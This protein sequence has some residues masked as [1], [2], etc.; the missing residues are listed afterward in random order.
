MSEIDNLR[1][2]G[3]NDDEVG[4]WAAEKRTTLQAAGFKDN[5]IDAYL[6]GGVTV[7]DN[8]PDAMVRRLD[9]GEEAR[10][11]E[12]GLM[13]TI[14]QFAHMV[15]T[16][17][18]R[19]RLW[20]AVKSYPEQ[21]MKGFVDQLKVPGDVVNGTIDLNT[22]EGLDQAIGLGTLVGLG[23][24]NKL[25]A[26]GKTS[27][28]SVNMG[29]PVAR[30]ERGPIGE[31]IDV[32]VG[33]LPRATDF[34][35]TARTIG[36]DARM[37]VQEKLLDL[38]ENKGIHPAEIAADAARDPVVKQ[39]IL[40]SD[41]ADLPNYKGG[42]VPPPEKPPAAPP[43]P[44]EPPEPGSFEAAQKTVLDKVS[45]GERDAR[46]MS[47]D[48]L[49]TEAIDDLH[50]I[51]A[52][53]E[54]AYQLARLTRGQFGKAAHFLEQGTFDF[55]T[56]K[57][58]GKPLKE[59]LAPVR[60]DLDG[61]RAYLTAKR[62][63]EIEGQGKKS[64]IETAAARQVVSEGAAKF[65]KA[66]AGIVEFQQ[67]QLKY[68]RDS[69][70]LSDKAF[71]AMVE[72]NKN[73]VPFYRVFGAGDG[74]PGGAGKGFGPGNPT[75]ALKGSD[76]GI[77]DPLESIIKNTYA[78]VSI[79]ERNAVGVKI[80]ETLKEQGLKGIAERKTN[81]PQFTD[82]EAAM[83]DHLK[84]N[85]VQNASELVDFVRTAAADEGTVISAWKD[86]K[87]I[88]VET[89]DAALVQA[90][91]GLD[92]QSVGLP[93]KIFA[94]PARTLRAGAVLTPDFMARNVTRDFMTAFINSKGLFSPIDTIKGAKS[95]LAKDDAY[96][97]W[98]KSGGANAT[99]VALD[100]RYMQ[101]SLTKLTA[102]TGLGTR[103]WNVVT[104]PLGAL[105]MTSELLENATR[106]GEFKK[107]LGEAGSK[108]AMQSAAYAS[109]EVTLDFARIGARMRGY[110]MVTAFAN[111]QIQGLDR[112]GRAFA[113]RPVNTTAKVAGGIVLPSV[114]LW[115]ANHGDQRYEELPDWQK[116]LFWIVLT[117]KWEP[118]SAVD[119]QNKPA[120][121]IREGK[122]GWEVNNGHIWRIPK[123]FE[124][125]VLFGSG[126]ERMLS[127]TLGKDKE[128][129]EGFSKSMQSVLTPSFVPT[130]VQ[131]VFEQWANRSSFTDRTLIPADVE[132]QLPEYQYTPYTTELAKKLGQVVAAFPGMR[133]ASVEPGAVGGPAAR[134][135]SSPILIE[136]Y[137]RSWTGGLGMYALQAADAALRKTGALPDPVTP[138]PTLADIPFIRAFAVRYPS[139]GTESIQK[140]Y[141]EH[142]RD[143][144]YFDTWM[145]KAKEG[146]AD[147]MG[148]IEAA[149]GP[150]M[151]LRLDAIKDV[152]SEH[153]KL[154]RDV[155][156]NPE[157]KAE[158][159]RQLIDGLYY[160][161][162]EVGKAG[163]GMLREAKTALGNGTR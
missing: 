20:D 14:P 99:M 98:V 152:L 42:E 47:W 136:N 97:A 87:R 143:K 54:D 35:D 46:P 111:A 67:A 131:P 162:I 18:G 127:A 59:I 27:G 19:S 48:K 45:V 11:R 142:E 144:R 145:A 104:N 112:I 84:Q 1:A 100:R 153:S 102:D 129:F 141:D 72:A 33:T 147:A 114:L 113:D 121:L 24:L 126:T 25:T 137:I 82:A 55:K 7:P 15:G 68:L 13:Q 10:A 51:K 105:R 123:P 16:P 116:D 70:V 75:K 115:Y 26:T 37:P 101:E 60:D 80:I 56:Y 122:A 4:A 158:E 117:D 132:K 124:L 6:V 12:G 103:A 58:T 108:E 41:K 110:N 94:V 22:P 139:A 120:H 64:G 93:T 91:R 43:K 61:M 77:V 38:Y 135:L 150:R 125:G 50:P 78:Y 3:F 71:D 154:V 49:Y 5:E 109:R 29:E 57:T 76:R 85:G 92:E 163:R 66:A 159:K 9:A 146:D 140:F 134:A 40:S 62:A 65:E 161:M 157:I 107:A 81:G 79:A 2:A 73:Y 148:R 133:E 119:A 36:G 156:K 151:F 31:I 106:V 90:F 28:L 30:I 95:V 88:S 138:T 53:S 83:I 86:G 8:A 21:F 149:G 44:P 160:S 39:S 69:G 155:Y 17:E 118:V 34:V 63:L 74:G 130:A 128:A 23:R 32:P 89:G 96:S 52:V